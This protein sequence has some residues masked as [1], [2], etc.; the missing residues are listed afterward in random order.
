MGGVTFKI[1]SEVK[2]TCGSGVASAGL[3]R[4]VAVVVSDALRQV[5]QLNH[6]L[7]IHPL[8]QVLSQVVPLLS[9][10]LQGPGLVSNSI[11]FY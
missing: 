11:I 9:L 4:L 3:L 8:L 10:G 1:A 7:R 5:T 6:T 2:E